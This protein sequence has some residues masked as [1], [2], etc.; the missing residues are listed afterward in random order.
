[1]MERVGLIKTPYQ[2]QQ[3]FEGVMPQPTVLPGQTTDYGTSAP[4]TAAPT[5][6]HGG[7]G[8]N[9]QPQGSSEQQP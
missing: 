7:T 2:A 9:S 8:N 6:T 3:L 5:P 1:M 4:G